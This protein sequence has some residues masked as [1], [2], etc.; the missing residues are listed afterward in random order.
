MFAP[1]LLQEPPGKPQKGKPI[2]VRHAKQQEGS[3]GLNAILN[4]KN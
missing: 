2:A 1:V 4:S 3:E